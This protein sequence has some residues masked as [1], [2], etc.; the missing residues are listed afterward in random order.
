MMPEQ[1]HRPDY[2]SVNDPSVATALEQSRNGHHSVLDPYTPPGVPHGQPHVVNFATISSMGLPIQV[3]F[4][5][6]TLARFANVDGVAAVA[7]STLCEICEVGSKNTIERWLGLAAQVGILRKE[8][9]RG[10]KDRKSN[11]YTFLGKDRNWLPLPVSHP[12]T[13]AVIALAEA[14]L[15]IEELQLKAA[16]V[17]E[18]ESHLELVMAENALLRNGNAI[19]H[20][21][22]TNGHTEAPGPAPSQGNESQGPAADQANHGPIGHPEVTNGPTRQSPEDASDSYENAE[23]E[24]WEAPGRAIGH[25]GV[26]NGGNEGEAQKASPSYNSQTESNLGAKRGAIGHSEVTDGTETNPAEGP[27]SYESQVQPSSQGGPAAIGHSEVTNGFQEGQ[28]YLARRDR[29][30]ALV[31]EH[32][33]YYERSFNRR[34]ILGAIEY[35]SRTE[36]NEQELLRQVRILEAGEDPQKAGTDPAHDT[37]AQTQEEAPDRYAVGDCPDCHRPF[38]T[39]RGARYCTDCTER[40]RRESEA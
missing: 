17:D 27:D 32:R 19:G 26:T 15:I 25:S 24:S 9:T 38:G 2:T 4:V 1:S 14:R 20:S 40:R 22:V 6:I 29:V 31:Q 39:Y 8:P 35:F 37:A 36:E 18:L 12:D 3:R 13:V 34:G 16:R 10:G 23:S 11:S 28:E 5:I 7:I 21:M 30:E 33:S